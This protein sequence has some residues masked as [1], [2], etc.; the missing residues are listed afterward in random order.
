[1]GRGMCED[2]PRSSLSADE[3]GERKRLRMETGE[4][5]PWGL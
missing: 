5:V 2:E 1:M 3:K 4:G